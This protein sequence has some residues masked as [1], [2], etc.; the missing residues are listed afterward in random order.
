MGGENLTALDFIKINGVPR[1]DKKEGD[2][3]LQEGSPKQ[4]YVEFEDNNR[5]ACYSYYFPEKDI[6]EWKYSKPSTCLKTCKVGTPG[7]NLAD[8]IYLKSVGPE[9]AK[10]STFMTKFEDRTIE[11][12]VYEAFEYLKSEEVKF[13]S[14]S[15][16]NFGLFEDKK[17]DAYLATLQ[18]NSDILTFTKEDAQK[19]PYFAIGGVAIGSYVS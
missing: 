6:N 3:P 15:F 10:E 9:G 8:H 16:D 1:A 13:N 2:V 14:D 7:R 4:G 11:G 12:K 5:A 19:S 17:T 18:L